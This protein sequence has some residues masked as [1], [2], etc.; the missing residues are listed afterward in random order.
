M[1]REQQSRRT[2]IGTKF[3]KSSRP[4][5]YAGKHFL[6]HRKFTMGEGGSQSPRCSNI[7]FCIFFQK[8]DEIEKKVLVRGRHRVVPVFQGELI[9]YLPFRVCTT[10][11]STWSSLLNSTC[12]RTS[13]INKVKNR[14]DVKLTLKYFPRCSTFSKW[15]CVA[16]WVSWKVLHYKSSFWVIWSTN[17]Q[18]ELGMNGPGERPSCLLHWNQEPHWRSRTNDQSVPRANS[19]VMEWEWLQQ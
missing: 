12:P 13:A 4:L 18:V 8:L 9:V 16:N 6:N 14:S 19:K 10:K 7:E 1:L 17:A 11:L 15:K 5:T 2:C 3:S